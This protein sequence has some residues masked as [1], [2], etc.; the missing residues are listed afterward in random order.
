MHEVLSGS[1]A[2]RGRV[3][4]CAGSD[5]L[6]S[7]SAFPVLVYLSDSLFLRLFRYIGRPEWL[8]GVAGTASSAVNMVASRSSSSPLLRYLVASLFQ[9]ILRYIA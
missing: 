8:R 9:R 4:A 1:E 5:L 6:Y 2:V 7:S 3:V